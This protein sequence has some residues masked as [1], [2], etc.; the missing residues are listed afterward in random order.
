MSVDKISNEITIS[1]STA[2]V[3]ILDDNKSLLHCCQIG[4]TSI[5]TAAAAAAVRCQY[6]K[7]FFGTDASWAALLTFHGFNKHTNGPNKLECLSMESL[8]SIM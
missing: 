7:T 6:Y 8:S 4:S 5:A 1:Q 3:Y 2:A